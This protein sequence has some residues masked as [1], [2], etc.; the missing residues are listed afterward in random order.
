MRKKSAESERG[1]KENRVRV[2]RVPR[3]SYRARRDRGLDTPSNCRTLLFDVSR[4]Q[5]TRALGFPLLGSMLNGF[6]RTRG[7]RPYLHQPLQDQAIGTGFPRT[8]G[9]RPKLAHD[10]GSSPNH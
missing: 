10:K 2:G 6:P 5:P 9:D 3:T 8:R 4:S 1:G 7:D